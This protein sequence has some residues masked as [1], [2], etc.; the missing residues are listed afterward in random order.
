MRRLVFAAAAFLAVIAVAV[1]VLLFSLDAIVARAI[2]QQGGKL[3][4]TAVS[5][6]RVDLELAAGRGRLSGLVVEN[7]DGFLSERALEL[8]DISLTLDPSSATQSPFPIQ[9]LRVGRSLVWLE[10]D[11]SGRSNLD[12]I[13]KHA[14]SKSER[15]APPEKGAEET[16]IRIDRLRFEGGE[17]L[18]Q[19]PGAKKPD[20]LELPPFT[21]TGVGGSKGATGTEIGHQVLRELTRR[22]TVATAGH[23]LGR[24]LE[25]ELG[26]AGKAAGELIRDLFD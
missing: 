23:E 12:R 10:I 13:R 25:K 2:E 21:L 15:P 1:A 7:P 8:S 11:A 4:G 17:I 16:R 18:L 26:E 3:T 5:V 19:R 24:A 22:V 6:D 20:R 14:G 9:E